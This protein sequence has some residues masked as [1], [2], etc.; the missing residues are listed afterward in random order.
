MPRCH[1]NTS[2]GLPASLHIDL[3]TYFASGIFLKKHADDIRERELVAFCLPLC[4][5]LDAGREADGDG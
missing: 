4:R 2:Q 5:E 1:K 3:H